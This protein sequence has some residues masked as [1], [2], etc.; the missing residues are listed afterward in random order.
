MGSLSFINSSKNDNEIL[1]G[2]TDWLL[3]RLEYN[4]VMLTNGRYVYKILFTFDS[5]AGGQYKS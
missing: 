2:P 4:M 3:C 1:A 5:E